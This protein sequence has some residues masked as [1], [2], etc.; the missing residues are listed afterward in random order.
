MAS[1]SVGFVQALGYLW[2]GLDA[3]PLRI[4]A[5]VVP[6]VAL[7]TLN[8]IGVRSGVRA[9]TFLVVAKLVPLLVFVFAGAFAVST[10]RI[11]E[12]PAGSGRLSEAAL[13]LLFAYAY[14]QDKRER[15]PGEVSLIPLP[16]LQIFAVVVCIVMLG[17]LVTL[18]SGVPFKGRF[19]G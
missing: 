1:L 7:T 8:V 12:Q 13:L 2:P 16:L 6:I 10:R 5:I 14:W 19:G 11:V 9:A 18:V 15:E 3:G 4:A 17:H